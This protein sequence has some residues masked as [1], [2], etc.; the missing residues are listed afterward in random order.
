V[1]V[2]IRTVAPAL[3]APFRDARDIARVIRTVTGPQGLEGLARPLPRVALDLIRAALAE[4]LTSIVELSGRQRAGEAAVELWAE[5]GLLILAVRFGGSP[6][7]EWLVANWSRDETPAALAPPGA[8]GWR[9][10]IVREAVESVTQARGRGGNL[11]FL[12]KRL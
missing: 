1:S 8:C 10:L 12:E 11:L 9:W 4:V 2:V 3:E 5:P 7:P 6:L